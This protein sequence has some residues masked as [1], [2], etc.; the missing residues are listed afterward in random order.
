ME[1]AEHV[2]AAAPESGKPHAFTAGKAAVRLA[3]RKGR[4]VLLLLGFQLKNGS[5][6]RRAGTVDDQAFGSN[7]LSSNVR[8]RDRYLVLHRQLLLRLIEGRFRGVEQ[9]EFAVTL[10]AET[11]GGRTSEEATVVGTAHEPFRD[12]APGLLLVPALLCHNIQEIS[13]SNP[14]KQRM[15]RQKPRKPKTTT[16][17]AETRLDRLTHLAR[18]SETH[19]A[20]RRGLGTI[21]DERG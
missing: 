16:G 11:H 18:N 1:G 8:S 21:E 14:R 20:D 17:F 2:A 10:G 7:L 5:A 15:K 13:S 4:G 9:H 19:P 12:L 6:A 3:W